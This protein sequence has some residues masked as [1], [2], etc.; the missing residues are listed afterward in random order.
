MNLLKVNCFFIFRYASAYKYALFVFTASLSLQLLITNHAINF[1]IYATVGQKFRD[2][3]KKLC[4]IVALRRSGERS[5][6]IAQ[7]GNG[8]SQAEIEQF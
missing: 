1:L 2:D 8:R 5:N 7:E 6:E 3:V 4:C